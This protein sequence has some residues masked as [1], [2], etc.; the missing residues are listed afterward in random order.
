AAVAA[1]FGDGHPIDTD[2]LERFLHVFDLVR[3]D[4][5]FNLFH[6]GLLLRLEVIAFFAVHA[7]V[8]T[9]D[10]ILFAGAH[11][12]HR[13]AHFENNPCADNRESPGDGGADQVVENLAGVAIYQAH[14]LA[15]AQIVNFFGGEN[16]GENG[17]HGASDAVDSEGIERVVIAELFL[18][19]ADHQIT[20]SA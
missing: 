4:D 3:L 19:Y 15:H 5:G 18:D 17:S 11:A 9:F 6:G 13:V 16:A 14:G 12:G 20:D 2:L 1:D 7:Q 10:L 8:E